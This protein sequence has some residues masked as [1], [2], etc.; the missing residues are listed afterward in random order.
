MCLGAFLF[1]FILYGILWVSWTWVVISF[2]ILGNFSTLISSNIFSYSFSLHF[3]DPYNSNV[4][5]FNT[6][7][8]IFETV[9]NSFHFFFFLYSALWQLLRSS[10]WLIVGGFP[11]K[12]SDLTRGPPTPAQR[13]RC[14]APS[15]QRRPSHSQCQTTPPPSHH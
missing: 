4:G 6:V 11:S 7:P 15:T 10:W 2:P 9:L 8:E 12:S 5:A 14:T 13:S 3:W 1:G